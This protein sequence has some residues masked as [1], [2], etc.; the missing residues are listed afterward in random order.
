MGYT[1]SHIEGDNFG[2]G[3]DRI[4]RADQTRVG[5]IFTISDHVKHSIVGR[6]HGDRVVPRGGGGEC[7]HFVA[8]CRC[9]CVLCARAMT[10]VRETVER[11]RG[12]I[13]A[14]RSEGDGIHD[15]RV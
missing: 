2:A 4:I 5:D 7:E 8:T 15:V 1:R 13:A 3:A 11:V 10:L 14:R 12:D 6:G 9:G